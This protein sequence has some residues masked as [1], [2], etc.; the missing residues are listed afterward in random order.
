MYGGEKF[1]EDTMKRD[2]VKRDLC[3]K[4]GILLLY[5]SNAGV[6]YPY[7]VIENFASLLESIQK[8]RAIDVPKQL[9][10]AQWLAKV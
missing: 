5:F 1:F 10:M 6:E 3:K 7:P 8:R 9:D 4:H 2:A